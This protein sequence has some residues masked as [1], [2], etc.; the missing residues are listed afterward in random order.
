MLVENGCLID[1]GEVE[2]IRAKLVEEDEGKFVGYND[3]RLN[4]PDLVEHSD[5][6]VEPPYRP[7]YQS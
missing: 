4:K 7:A 3:S 1:W 5:T 2:Q 6:P